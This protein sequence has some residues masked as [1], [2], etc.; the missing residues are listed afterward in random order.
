MITEDKRHLY[1]I[2]LLVLAALLALGVSLV[3]YFTADETPNEKYAIEAAERVMGIPIAS[4]VDEGVYC[5]YKPDAPE[6]GFSLALRTNF[7]S[8]YVLFMRLALRLSEGKLS[9]IAESAPSEIKSLSNL[10]NESYNAYIAYNGK[11]DAAYVSLAQEGSYFVFIYLA[12]Q[13]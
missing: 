13:N 12:G 7:P 11:A 1:I 3:V 5:D 2:A 9:D 8:D 10:S 4:Y 6:D